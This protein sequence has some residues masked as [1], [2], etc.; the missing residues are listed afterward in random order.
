MEI[1]R[2]WW[3]HEGNRRVGIAEFIDFEPSSS[4]AK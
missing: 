3:I 4:K 2:K 1:G